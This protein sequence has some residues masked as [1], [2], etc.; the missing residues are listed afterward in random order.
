MMEVRQKFVYLCSNFDGWTAK[1]L[2][3]GRFA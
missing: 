3:M 1:C 2:E